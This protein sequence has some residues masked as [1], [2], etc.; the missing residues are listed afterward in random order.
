ML[1]SVTRPRAHARV[2]PAFSV[3][4]RPPAPSPSCEFHPKLTRSAQRANASSTPIAASTWE[5]ATLPEEQAAPELTMMP[6][7][8]SAI[9]AVSAAT[10]GRAKFEVL[11][12]RGASAPKIATYGI[13]AFSSCSKPLRRPAIRCASRAEIGGR[14]RPRRSRRCAAM[15]SVPARRRFSCPPPKICARKRRCRVHDQRAHALRPAQLVRRDDHVIGLA[16]RHLA[17]GLHRIDHATARPP[18]ASGRESLPAAGSRRSRCWRPSR[19]PAPGP[20]LRAKPCAAPPDRAHRPRLP[21][22]FRAGA[23]APFRPGPSHWRA[24]NHVRWPRRTA[25]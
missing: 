20:C 19:P 23:P 14:P 25:A 9:T 11:A 21:A 8:S 3:R 10:P 1:A 12:S 15:F 6:S 24:R 17:G 4:R 22:A 16:Q 5:R 13:A 18:P 7:R 2:R